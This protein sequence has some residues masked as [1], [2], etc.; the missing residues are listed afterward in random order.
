[1]EQLARDMNDQSDVS[2][3]SEKVCERIPSCVSPSQPSS[4]DPPL[5][6]GTTVPV[7]F[8][9]HKVVSQGIRRQRDGICLRNRFDILSADDTHEDSDSNAGHSCVG[10]HDGGPEHAPA[11]G[12]RGAPRECV[13]PAAVRLCGCGCLHRLWHHAVHASGQARPVPSPDFLTPPLSLRLSGGATTPSTTCCGWRT[14]V[15]PATSMWT[16]W[17]SSC[18]NTPTRRPSPAL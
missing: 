6:D 8:P 9:P 17:C 11:P 7:E 13:H 18:R 5:V 15:R 3:I 16:A 12:R 14:S 2:G 1:M 4:R 10:P